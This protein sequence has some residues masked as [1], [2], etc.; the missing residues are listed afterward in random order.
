MD[1]IVR[2]LKCLPPAPD[3]ERV[4]APGEI[5]RQNEAKNRV[6]GVPLVSSVV[7]QLAALGDELNVGFPNATTGEAPAEA[8]P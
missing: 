6:L 4:L 8:R 2:M 1:E 5:E 7:D 3:V